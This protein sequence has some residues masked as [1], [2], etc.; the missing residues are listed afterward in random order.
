MSGARI[1]IVDDTPSLV[2]LLE[3]V[4]RHAGYRNLESTTDPRE[5]NRL[6]LG[7]WPDLVLLDLHMPNKDG[8]EVLVELRA[9]TPPGSYLPVVILTA[10]HDVA[11]KRRALELGASDFLNK[12]F[13]PTEVALRV[14]NL[15]AT[16]SLHVQLETQNRALDERVRERTR[17]VEEA[18]FETLERL[19]R[20]AEYRDDETGLHTQRV[21]TIA[22]EIAITIGLD[23]TEAE[24]LGLAA[25]LHDLG[26]IGVSDRILL[27]P[28]PLTT[29][30][31]EAMKKHCAIGAAILADA[32]TELMKLAEVLA[33]THHERW[34]GSG[35]PQRLVGYEIPPKSRIVAVAD[36]FDALT[37]D[38]VYRRAQSVDEAV[39]LIRS[40]IGTHFDPEV[41][42]ALEV[43]LH[44]KLPGVRR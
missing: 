6:F 3:E 24:I 20:A 28:G 31:F 43:V 2:L 13:D 12:P 27:K 44:H 9:L 39:G 34:D 10:D 16:R 25:P 18:R 19:A 21:G 5:A 4:L 26:K 15:L 30:E 37:H 1:L 33:L 40:G 36:V 38:R 23:R 22:E 14:K 32:R 29:D 35:Y 17:E 11:A 8:F 7:F 41:V 42:A